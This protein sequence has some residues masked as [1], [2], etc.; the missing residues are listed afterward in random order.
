MTAG[1]ETQAIRRPMTRL[2]GKAM[3][4][5]RAGGREI[6]Y[7]DEEVI[8][9]AGEEGTA[10]YVLTEGEAEVVLRDEGGR[11]LHLAR[12]GVGTSFGEMSLLTGAPVSA[13]VVARGEARALS[14]PVELFE[15][16]LSECEPLR[17]HILARLA[18]NLQRTNTEAWSLF[19]RAEALSA[20]MQVDDTGGEIIAKSRTMRKVAEQIE[21]F[22]GSPDPV[23]ITGEPGTGKLF[24]AK[25][26][27][28]AGGAADRPLI[29]VNCQQMT[30]LDLSKLLFG[31]SWPPDKEGACLGGFGAV[32]LANGGT[33]VI[34]HAESLDAAS[35]EALLAYLEALG[36]PDRQSLPEV[37]LIATTSQNLAALA[38]DGR[39]R[40][41]LFERL[42]RQA[43]E[44]PRLAE[45]RHDI[46]PLAELFL[47]EH[48][49]KDDAAQSH[50]TKLA[51]HA[52]LTAQYRHHNVTE[53]REAVQFAPIVAGSAEI[54]AE[55]IFTGPKT[56]EIG[57][58][59]DLGRLKFV[60]ILISQN[61][62][63]LLRIAVFG[64]FFAIGVVCLAAG[65]TVAGRIA[66]GLTWGL[67]W[68]SLAVLFLFVGRV[69]CTVCP[70]SSAARFVQGRASLKRNPPAWLK[71]HTAWIT[72][73]LFFLIVWCEHVFEMTHRP[74]ATGIL[75]L[76]LMVIASG[77]SVLF[78]R[79]PWC[80]YLCPLGGLGASYS[81]PSIIHVHA[82]PNVCGTQCTTHQCVKGSENTEGCPMFIHPLYVRDSQFCKLCFECVRACPHASARPYLRPILHGLWGQ[83]DLNETLAPFAVS[84]FFLS[85]AMLSS[86]G[87][88]WAATS[89]GFTV[90]SLVALGTALAFYRALPGML[91]KEA[92]ADPSLTPRVAFALLVLGWGALMAFHL[93]H[94]PGLGALSIAVAEGSAV[95]EHLGVR[96]I[97]VGPL[98]KLSAILLGAVLALVS[99]WRIHAR[100]LREDTP[101]R[102]WGWRAILAIGL[103]YVV[104]AISFA[105]A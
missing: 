43:L 94:V 18:N 35:Q 78:R 49:Q 4:Y 12:L 33:L 44:L 47:R 27:H 57:P 28:Q 55:H 29:V 60:Q 101:L 16:A 91:L 84:V 82:N 75:L 20:L 99:L 39:F 10:F 89:W 52:L 19:Q 42:S 63:R 41:P 71:K 3:D 24:A 69:W 34:R 65:Q 46:L 74:F 13:D 76:S 103:A 96:Q 53:L 73:L 93:E 97:S 45:R 40:R 2:T 25:K 17:R 48:T 102:P 23:L 70:V 31:G 67:W 85:M 15:T 56:H 81:A 80:R 98:L 83:A 30:D 58:S 8:I 50:F 100:A 105:V 37:R 77:L 1:A 11:R 32:H 87:E 59:Y 21:Q 38:E 22:G 6:T 95:A 64:I 72:A 7:A 90:Y 51:E 14:Y 5:L 26:V 54:D 36:A 68:P 104:A 62:H 61:V 92:D 86:V 88:G 79:E 9:A 66:N